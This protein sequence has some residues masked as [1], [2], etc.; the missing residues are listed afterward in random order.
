MKVTRGMQ[1]KSAKLARRRALIDQQTLIAGIDIAKRE[2]V[3]VF[4]RASDK[5]RLGQLRIRTDAA[6]VAELS[7][8]P[9]FSKSAMAW[10]AW[11]WA[12]RR[13]ATSGSYWLVGPASWRCPT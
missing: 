4:L 6:G 1:R 8:A 5:R 2:S 12:W 9:S 13:P 3:V 7:G 11:S 10:A